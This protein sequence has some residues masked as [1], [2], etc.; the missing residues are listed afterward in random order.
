MPSLPRLARSS[1]VRHPVAV[2]PAELT[3]GTTFSVAQAV[4]GD[5]PRRPEHVH[6]DHGRPLPDRA[7]ACCRRPDRTPGTSLA[8]PSAGP[9]ANWRTCSARPT[10]A[11]R[12]KA[13]PP[14]KPL[15]A[16]LLT[17]RTSWT[18]TAKTRFSQPWVS[19]RLSRRYAPV[20]FLTVISPHSAFQVVASVDS[21]PEI[22]AQVQEIIIPIIVL[23]LENKLLGE[24]TVHSSY[25][26]PQLIR[27]R[28]FRQ[29]VRARG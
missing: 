10:L 14:R 21:S 1:R 24:S 28:P 25:R 12:G 11:W 15:R 26:A 3:S 18:T 20:I 16:R 8:Y 6:G 27:F 5:G 13:L 29:H 7:P 4:G 23:T 2:Y 22:L 19:L 17:W 9:G